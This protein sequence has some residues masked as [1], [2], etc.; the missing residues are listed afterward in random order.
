MD[1]FVFALNAVLPI[2]LMVTIG[3]ILK[4]IGFI[5]GDM[6]KK[7]NRLVFRVFLPVMVFLNVYNIEDMS[8]I[9][10]TFLLYCICAVVVVVL[11]AAVP[12]FLVT[13]KR[14][15]RGALIQSAFRS[16]YTLIGVPLAASLFGA[17]GEQTAT[18]ML[19][20][21]VPL[22]NILAVVVLSVFDD[23]GKRINFGKILLGIIKNPLILGVIAG[24]VALALRS[25][26]AGIDVNVD[27][28]SIAPISKVLTYL[29]SLATPLAL[30]VLGA[31]FEF[32]AVSELRREIIL[33]TLMRSLAV[34]LMAIGVAYVFFRDNFDGAQFAVLVALFSTPVAVSSVPMAQEMNSDVRLAGQLVVWTTVASG[35]TVFLVSFA[36]S[37][38]GVFP[39]N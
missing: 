1:S 22:F 14:D 37:L 28:L 25:A 39:T 16:N 3:Y 26:F 8:S 32:S 10:A 30:I 19:A 15:R 35:I 12:T 5:D 17:Q 18:V 21:A 38:L 2:I 24:A 4:R 34:P 9:D 11:I 7:L 29:S 20:I 31:Q 33:G 36:L 6:P 23:S 27:I 13:D